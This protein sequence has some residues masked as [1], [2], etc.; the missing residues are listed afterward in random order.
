MKTLFTLTFV[1]LISI[2]IADGVQPQGTGS[3]YD[4]FQIATLDN[5]LWLSTTQYLWDYH[6]IQTSDI[7][8]SD[9]QNWNNG[10]GFI[11]IGLEDY[12]QLHYDGQGFE[13]QNLFI[14]RPS[15]DNIGMFSYTYGSVEDLNLIN[16]NIIG[17]NSVGIIAGRAGSISNCHVSG[18]VVGDNFVGGLAASASSMVNCS[19]SAYV[20]SANDAFGGLASSISNITNSYYDMDQVLINGINQ[21]TVGGIPN[22]IYSDWIANNYQL[23]ISDYLTDLNDEFIIC[24]FNDFEKLLAFGMQ[25]SISFKLLSDIDLSEHPNFYIPY[26]KANFNGSNQTISNLTID[27]G[28]SPKGLFGQIRGATIEDLIL[29]NV[30]I[31]SEGRVGSIAG[32]S[33]YS[34]INRCSAS[35]S[36]EGNSYVAGLVGLFR[37]GSIITGSYSTVNVTGTHNLSGLC[38]NLNNHYSSSII[39]SFYNYEAVTIN[40]EH[41]ITNR[42]ISNELFTTWLANGMSL[43]I[44]DYFS[45]VSGSY[46]INSVTD[47][48]NLLAFSDYSDVR[49]ALI[50][51][52]DLCDEPNLHIPYLSADFEGYNNSISNCN[53]SDTH[54]SQ[55]LFGQIDNVAIQN[56]YVLNSTIEGSNSGIIAGI[57][58]NSD[59]TNC[60]ASGIINGDVN[61]GGIASFG[62][63]TTITNCATEVTIN[64]VAYIGG[65][66]GLYNWQDY[67]NLDNSIS[68]CYSFSH[69]TGEGYMGGLIGHFRDD[70][71]DGIKNS[72]SVS[73]ITV[74]PNPDDPY[75]INNYVGGLFGCCDADVDDCFWDTDVC[76]LEE[77][78]GVAAN[79]HNFDIHGLP[80]T[81]M[82][83]YLNFYQQGWDFE[84]TWT[85]NSVIN[86]SYPY[87]QSMDQTVDNF[88]YEN[89]Q[90]Q[91]QLASLNSAYPNPFN[92]ETTIEF[93]IPKNQKG[94][95]TIFNIKGQVVKDYPEFEA[96]QHSVIWD[97]TNVNN[98]KVCSGVYFYRLDSDS[99]YSL[100]KM[101]LIK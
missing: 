86:N 69:L 44:D 32:E 19:S 92:P 21:L 93:F 50:R 7:D 81:E 72:Y 27:G 45:F 42:A 29:D 65:I 58:T 77:S 11:P 14:N 73:E 33:Y 55:G 22:Y 68:N 20:T 57:A 87:L 101:V 96:G 88:E 10:A 83:D 49:F 64:G 37:D 6:F 25:D 80:T 78:I 43:N 61:L 91:P 52:I 39:N 54:G 28:A 100:K 17:H 79:S 94:T 53:I 8:A 59:I 89:H 99:V 23:N 97:G 15:T 85:V 3:E 16:A 98:G 31:V 71:T 4:P 76:S 47:F 46:L 12:W 26:F 36:V 9:T 40:D 38:N 75:Y 18:S 82:Q 90:S 62:L 84:N 24:D 67:T 56:L 95:L 5:L 60:F 63:D 74:I 1:F 13:I 51:D 2:L 35:G 30:S 70:E 34:V 66:C 41:I 48:K